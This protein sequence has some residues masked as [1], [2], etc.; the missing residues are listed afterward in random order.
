MTED[1]VENHPEIL[2]VQTTDVAPIS[3]DSENEAPAGPLAVT[4]CMP[5]MVTST[6]VDERRWF[7]WV[8]SASENE[9]HPRSGRQNEPFLL[10]DALP[11]GRCTQVH[12]IRVDGSGPGDHVADEQGPVSVAAMLGQGDDVG[13]PDRPALRALGGR[14]SEFERA[15]WMREVLR[16]RDSGGDISGMAVHDFSAIAIVSFT[17][18]A[19][20]GPIFVVDVWRGQGADWKLTVRYASPAGSPTFAVPG[21]SVSQPEIPKKY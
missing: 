1:G 17:Q 21:G 2:R 7:S 12:S 13:E 4:P 3:G 10:V 15:D 14:D 19:V 6:T 9:F 20:G 8:R 5:P 18:G 16:M 11:H